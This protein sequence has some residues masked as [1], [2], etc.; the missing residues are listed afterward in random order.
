MFRTIDISDA[1]FESDG[2]RCVTVKSAALRGRGDL[3][4]WA[5]AG[6][7]PAALVILLHGVYGSHWCWALKGGA[8]RTAARRLRARFH[9]WRWRCRATACGATAPATSGTATA[10]TSRAGSSTRSLSRRARPC[11]RWPRHAAVPRRPVDG[12]LRRAAARRDAR[13]TSGGHLRPLVDHARLADVAVHRGRRRIAA[14]GPGGSLGPRRDRRGRRALPPLRF[15]CGV[16]DQLIEENRALHAAR[17]RGIP[18]VYEEHPGHARV[19]V[20]GSARRTRETGVE[21]AEHLTGPEVLQTHGARVPLPARARGAVRLRPLAS[22]GQ[23]FA[24]DAALAPAAV[25]PIR[26]VRKPSWSG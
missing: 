20:L 10:P 24:V 18:H 1:R 9:P 7:T 8:H 6:A 3:T 21:P 26:C 17:S 13:R 22:A 11:R 2:L 15:D 4:V 5:P 16:A 25:T 23:V 12:W 14:Y 19:G